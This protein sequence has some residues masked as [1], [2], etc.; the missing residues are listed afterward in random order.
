VDE[1]VTKLL[2][3]ADLFKRWA[4]DAQ[5]WQMAK[6]T[7]PEPAY[8]IARDRRRSNLLTACASWPAIVR[9]PSHE[10]TCLAE[11]SLDELSWQQPFEYPVPAN[12][13]FGA[14]LNWVCSQVDDIRVRRLLTTFQ[15]PW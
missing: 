11:V 14:F 10:S 1:V 9:N 7:V 5:T 15:T 3:L 6:R 8:W 4:Y 12:L 2:E 13:F